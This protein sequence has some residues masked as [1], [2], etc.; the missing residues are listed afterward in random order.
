MGCNDSNNI[1]IIGKYTTT[2]GATASIPS[3]GSHTDGTWLPTDLYIGESL[4]NA[5]DG[6]LFYRGIN[7]IVQISGGTGSGYVDLDFVPASSGGTYSGGIYSP[8]YS[9]G[10]ANLDYITAG[11]ISTGFI[12]GTFSGDGSLLTNI[13]ATWNGG[14]VSGTSSFNSELSLNG[15][16]IINGTIS[17]IYDYIDFRKDLYVTGGVS[18]SYFIGD[19][20]LL[21]N[22]PIGATQNDYTTSAYLDGTTLHFD[23]TDTSDAYSVNLSTLVGTYSISSVAFDGVNL[24]LSTNNGDEFAVDITTITN[25]SSV[26]TLNANEIYVSDAYGTF[27]GVFS[28]TFSGDIYTSNVVLSD[29]D[30]VFERTNGETY[31]VNLSA[32]TPSAP[33][34]GSVLSASNIIG[35]HSI[36]FGNSLYIKSNVDG[37]LLDGLDSDNSIILQT[38]TGS[39]YS[40]ITSNKNIFSIEK[41]DDNI[42]QFFEQD[43]NGTVI[44]T[45]SINED[46]IIAM[47]MSATDLITSISMPSIPG[48]Y[49]QQTSSVFKDERILN[50][51]EYEITQTKDSTFPKS[52]TLITQIYDD[53]QALR[54]QYYNQIYDEVSAGVNQASSTLTVEAINHSVLSDDGQ[55]DYVFINNEGVN[56]GE[57]QGSSYTN[58]VV[59]NPTGFYKSQRSS[60]DISRGV[61][62]ERFVSIQTTNGATVSVTYPLSGLEIG[63]GALAIKATVTALN[64]VEDKGYVAELYAAVRINSYTPT[65]FGNDKL[66]KTEFTTATA[67]IEIESSNLAI[68]VTGENAT[69]IDWSIKYEVIYSV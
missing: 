42:L 15:H 34:L 64:S 39:T 69:T 30:L 7:G 18:A 37:M 40:N 26:S 52:Q 27:H 1:R 29:N 48:V 28:G 22:L 58:F 50:N 45:E 51:G 68:R 4:F 14:T 31:S 9:G 59:N 57:V 65:I 66:Q 46:R 63:T 3:S 21:T 47:T 6:T 5:V 24:T 16:T 17:S 49:H 12:I 38:G 60:T 53:T 61:S 19:G 55:E 41:S 25:L 43:L 11:T 67:N 35:T 13:N 62:K 2:P 33:T 23:R 32:L 36:D 54:Q 20:S 44:K 10:N 8:T 56:L